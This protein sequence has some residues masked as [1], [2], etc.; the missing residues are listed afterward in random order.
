[1]SDT[2]ENAA[3]TG[4]ADNRP[5]PRGRQ[6]S[7]RMLLGLMA[8]TALLTFG[9]LALAFSIFERK[10]E[11]RHPFVRV[12]EVNEGTSDP[13]VWGANWPREYESYKRTVDVTRTRYGGSEAMPEQ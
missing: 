1:M 8:L 11:A 9:L 7:K 4:E 10:Q 6:W 2:P 12:V 5:G 13:A 3:G